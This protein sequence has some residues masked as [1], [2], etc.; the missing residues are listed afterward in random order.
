MKGLKAS[1]A[2]LVHDVQYFKI[3][4]QLY[5]DKNFIFKK[6]FY[7]LFNKKLMFTNS[8]SETQVFHLFIFHCFDIIKIQKNRNK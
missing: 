3:P 4:Y 2:I 1:H 6:F 7:Y 5:T 8:K